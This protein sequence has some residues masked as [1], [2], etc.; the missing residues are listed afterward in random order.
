MGRVGFVRDL[1]AYDSCLELGSGREGN[2]D[3]RDVSVLYVFPPLTGV[4]DVWGV[5]RC[6]GN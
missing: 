2:S 1:F 6:G 5:V 3:Q 4:S